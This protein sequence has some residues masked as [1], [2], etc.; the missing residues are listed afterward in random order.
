MKKMQTRLLLKAPWLD[1]LP[2]AV[3]AGAI[4]AVILCAPAA[5]A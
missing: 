2:F 5:F 4:V 3:C 1:E